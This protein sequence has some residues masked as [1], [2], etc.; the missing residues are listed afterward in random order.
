[1]Q[2][3][4]NTRLMSNLKYNFPIFEREILIQC[5]FSL[6]ILAYFYLSSKIEGFL[7]TNILYSD[8]SIYLVKFI[9]V[10]FCIVSV[11]VS[12]MA[13]KIQKINFAEYYYIVFLSILGLLLMISTSDLL[14]FYLTM[15]SQTLCFYVLAAINRNSLFSIEAGLKYFI[16]G[17]FISGIFLLGSSLIYGSLGT[18]NIMDMRLLLD[19]DLESYNALV[20]FFVLVGVILITVT[21]LFK[22]GC[23]PFHFWAPDVYE[24]SPISSTVIFSVVP[25]FAIFYFFMKWINSLGTIAENIKSVLFLFGIFSAFFG[26]FYALSQNRLKRLV[27]YS[28]VAQTG[29]LVCGVGGSS[30]D[31]YGATF[32]F[33]VLY[34]VTSLLVWGHFIIFY[35]FSQKSSNYDLGS[36]DPLYLSTITNFHSTNIIWSLSLVVILFSIGGIPPLGGF[37]SKILIISDLINNSNSL[38]AIFLVVISSISVYYYIKVLKV[39]YF[40]PKEKISSQQFKVVYSNDYFDVSN[41]ISVIFL[42]VLL[43]MF[44]NP[45]TIELFSQYIVINTLNF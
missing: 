30:I 40:E 2:I 1:M 36:T 41:A 17:S 34:L 12:F 37:L 7:S 45:S 20:K 26:T 4:F 13:N 3:L 44:Y 21:L 5:L 11:F 23:A 32:F 39:S 14:M 19:Y 31:S 9:F 16:V 35:L 6:T 28:S 10:I 25:K 18:T 27:A 33:L 22:L 43:V 24:G 29:F 15:E 42:F 8:A 38:V